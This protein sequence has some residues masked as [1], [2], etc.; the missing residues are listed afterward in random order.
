MTPS[1]GEVRPKSPG[2]TVKAWSVLGPRRLIGGRPAQSR[3]YRG[4]REYCGSPTM[5]RATQSWAEGGGA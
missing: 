2:A 3:K 4:Q 5:A 1:H